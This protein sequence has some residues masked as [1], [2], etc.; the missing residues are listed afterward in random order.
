MPSLSVVFVGFV[1]ETLAY[2]GH[3]RL[4]GYLTLSCLG[5]F[6]VGACR[7]VQHLSRETIER[8]DISLNIGAAMNPMKRM[9]PSDDSSN[10]AHWARE[11]LQSNWSCPSKLWT[12]YSCG[13]Q[14]SP[15]CNATWL[16]QIAD[17]GPRGLAFQ[18]EISAHEVNTGSQVEEHM[19][20]YR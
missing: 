12:I 14:D 9:R 17:A 5:P 13:S 4:D 7:K 1:D 10:R 18:S 2:R 16:A 15:F 11:C 8:L 3:D 19:S 20:E 6:D